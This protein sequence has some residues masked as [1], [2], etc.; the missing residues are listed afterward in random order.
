M[1][2]VNGIDIKEKKVPTERALT[3]R[4]EKRQK[5][6]AQESV[7]KEQEAELDTLREQTNAALASVSEEDAKARVERMLP[8]I[9]ELAGGEEGR[10][11]L[12]RFAAASLIVRPPEPVEAEE[13]IEEDEALPQVEDRETERAREDAER[14]ESRR[15]SPR[16]DRGRSGGGDRGR[17]GGGGGQR[18]RQR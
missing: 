14:P 11:E 18:R 17:S 1:Q 10:S 5:E 6:E 3:R 9:Q 13:V 4:L 2:T 12:A 8:F 16:G 15:R 7:R